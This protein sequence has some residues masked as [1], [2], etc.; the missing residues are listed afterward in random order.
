MDIHNEDEETHN[1]GD[2]DE[3]DSEV[4]EEEEEE[5]EEEKEGG[6]EEEEEDGYDVWGN[7]RTRILERRGSDVTKNKL[8]IL[9]QDLTNLYKN[10]VFELERLKRDPI[11]KKIMT[12]K[13]KFEEDEE[14]DSDEALEAA[15]ESR[16]YLMFRECKFRDQDVISNSDD[17]DDVDDEDNME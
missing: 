14:Y 12:T 17:D 11:H 8:P 4:K 16:K 1:E 9:K 2:G 5:E 15:I 7:M 3:S 13:R 10:K 6:G